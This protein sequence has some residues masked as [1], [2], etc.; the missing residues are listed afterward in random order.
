MKPIFLLLLLLPVFAHAAKT[1]AEIRQSIQELIIQRHPVIP[2]GFWEGLGSEAPPI[3]RKMYSESKNPVHQ[4]FLIDGLSHFHDPATA[5]FLKV[6]ASTSQN[7]VTRKKFLGAVIRS[8]GEAAFD[9]V[10]P[11]LKDESPHV[12]L[13]V[14]M[15]LKEYAQN[16]KIKARLDA[17]RKSEKKPWVTQELDRTQDRSE[18]QTVRKDPNRSDLKKTAETDAKVDS[19]LPEKQWS[20][21]WKGTLV[22]PLKTEAVDLTLSIV[23]ANSKPLKW[24]AELLLPK[25]LKQEWRS[26]DFVV[27]YFQSARAHWLEL[28]HPKL[29]A[30]LVAFRKTNGS[31]AG[32]GVGAK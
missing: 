26:G 19:P 16:D 23:D 2:Q 27:Q 1:E 6:K 25:K 14:A 29:D 17:F 30:V 22:Q 24:K 9:F 21:I 15:G 12:R 31:A 28:R 32:T 5:E 3:L 7:D 4:S 20:G 11:Y 10:E 13:T 18:I 8:E